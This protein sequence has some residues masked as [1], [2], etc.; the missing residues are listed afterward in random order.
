MFNSYNSY[1]WLIVIMA[2]I[3]GVGWGLTIGITM[4]AG[5][6]KKLYLLLKFSDNSKDNESKFNKKG[7]IVQKIKEGNSEFTY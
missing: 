5:S 6:I 1:D 3:C 7:T 4:W 2:S